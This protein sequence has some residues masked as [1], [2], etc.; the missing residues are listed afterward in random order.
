MNADNG[1]ENFVIEIDNSKLEKDAQRA[2]SL[3]EGIGDAAVRQGERLDKSASELPR[4]IEELNK[5]YEEQKRTISD[6]DKQI[7]E[8]KQLQELDKKEVQELKAAYEE[9]KKAKGEYAAQNEKKAYEEAQKAVQAEAD[10]IK[11]LNLNKQEYQHLNRQ[12]IESIKEFRSEAYKIPTVNE[13]IAESMKTVAKLS[14]GYLSYEGANKFIA[15][16]AEVRSEIEMLQTQM[17]GLFGEDAGGKIFSG[18]KE[19]ALNSGIYKTTGLSQVAETLNVYGEETEDIL[20]LMQQFGDVAMGNDQKLQSLANA[21]GRVT[22]QGSLSSLTLRTMIRA[23]FNPLDEMART[24]G[25]SMQQLRQEMSNGQITVDRVREAL[26]SA[27]SE[28]GK[29]YNMTEKLSS[30]I[31]GEQQRLASMI[32]GVY[33][34][35]GEEHE[36]LIKSSLK[37]RQALVAHYEDIGKAIAMLVGTYG[38]YRAAVIANGAVEAAMNAHYV[39]KIRLLRLAAVAQAA[40]NRVLMMNPYV[41]AATALGGLITAIALYS[42]KSTVAE[43]AAKRWNEGEKE[44]TEQYERRKNKLN[45][46]LSKINDETASEYDRQDALVELKK[47]LPSVF[48]KYD[49]WIELQKKLAET[50][51]MAN[52]QLQLQNAI[53]GGASNYKKNKELANDLREYQDNVRKWGSNAAKKALY[54]KHPEI[55]EKSWGFGGLKFK[56][57]GTLQSEWSAASD[58]LRKTNDK[59][60]DDVKQVQSTLATA[61]D[62]KLALKSNKELNDNLV[63]YEKELKRF[64]NANKPTIKRTRTK[65]GMS[66]EVVKPKNPKDFIAFKDSMGNTILLTED[67]VKRRIKKLKAEKNVSAN[68]RGR[69][70]LKEAQDE[71]RKKQEAERRVIANRKKYRTAEAYEADL[72]K[73][74]LAVKDAQATVDRREQDKGLKSQD[75]KGASER[76][77]AAREAKL[78]AEREDKAQ[79][80]IT[81]EQYKYARQTAKRA[82]ANELLAQQAVVDAMAEG[83]KKKLAQLDI[84]HKKELAA[85]DEEARQLYEAK[86]EHQKELWEADTKNEGKGFWTSHKRDANTG[87]VSGVDALTEEESKG[88]KAKRQSENVRY[89]KEVQETLRQSVDAMIGYY[90]QFGTLEEQ[91]YAIAKEYDEKI[92]KAQT[93]GE[94]RSLEAQKKKDLAT[95]GANSLAN[96][97]DW[98]QTFE[99][100]GNVLGSVAKET[101]RKVEEYMQTAEYKQLKP[102]DQKAYA[103]LREKLTKETGGSETSP[104][105]FKQWG[106]IAQQ[107]KEYQNSVQALQRITEEHRQAVN[108][109]QKA[110][111]N[112]SESTDDA[113]KQVAQA[114]VDAAQAKVDATGQAKEEAQ[115]AATEKQQQLTDSTSKATNGMRNFTSALQEISGGS[116]YGFAN[117]IT[118]LITSIGGTSKSLGELGGKV[119]GIVGAILQILDALGD[120]PTKFIDDILEKVTNTVEKILADL[121]NLVGHVIQDVGTLVGSVIEGI[122]GIF[123]AKDGWLY[124]SNEWRVKEVTE[125]LTKS[126]DALKTSIDQLKDAIDKEN[127]VNAITDTQRALQAQRSINENQRK[128]LEENMG[129]H[130]KHHSNAYYWGKDSWFFNNPFYT[131]LLRKAGINVPDGYSKINSILQDF[132]KRTPTAD[133]KLDKVGSLDDMYK[134]T[135]EQMNEIRTQNAE[136]W[137]HITTVGKYDMSKYWN[138]YA[139]QAGK[140]AE[141][142]DKLREKLT[143]ITFDS[144]HD[145]FVS[146]LMDMQ[147]K[148][149]DFTKDINKQFAKGLLNFSIGTQMDA[150]LKEWWKNWADT[151]QKQS[152]DL[153]DTQ[154][155]NMRREYEA[156]VSEGM[157]I[158]DKVF[159]VTGYD[160]ETYAQSSS[161]ASLSGITQDQGQELNGR[162]SS[163]QI[164]VAEIAEAI[165]QEAERNKSVIF[166]LGDIRSIMNDLM[167]LQVQGLNHLEAIERHTSVLPQMNERIDKIRRNTENS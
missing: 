94:R 30:S 66:E 5:A 22:T 29:Y 33:A 69:D 106:T 56:G 153:T 58:L 35:F 105:N 133:T 96:E 21:F 57:Q 161:S 88:V 70:Y 113:S 9:A 20:P 62:S 117:G 45:E 156:F 39:T 43:E 121:P 83:S 143:G 137:T 101:L 38:T 3:I 51:A 109:L 40:F 61:W 139:D 97:I 103:D 79:N 6:L 64:Q 90:K 75:R 110:E 145:D 37:L 120:D 142:A 36:D 25:K 127:G 114:A 82:E 125:R 59:L 147:N 166:S 15:K 158:R 89:G 128:M 152:G 60:K 140:T 163:I 73:A 28:G 34:K 32:A 26:K 18:L 44:Q 146:K 107:V 119:G 151:M 63:F 17:D 46:L 118:K 74:K 10:A 87:L 136:L 72:N 13:Q 164:H 47:I 76:A 53:N 155:D 108:E 111:K 78:Q 160:K 23:G 92:A 1:A 12:T 144:M 132:K 126:N 99:G 98:S 130:G 65:N 122:G 2:A 148:A 100:V 19:M 112:L 71:L 129:M 31:K 159:K 68:N 81:E 150:K 85:I 49:N 149:K 141:I 80:K 115:K 54:D 67:E 52:E 50:A 124:G 138:A 154:I 167:D 131:N 134:L 102:S 42:K 135:P 104:F 4:L 95:A 93:D 84:D 162:L 77:K 7:L 27:T 91:R 116:L 55:F 165:Q 123:G 8:H 41:L 16:A 14:L 11:Q 157:R 86:V 48:S 24:T